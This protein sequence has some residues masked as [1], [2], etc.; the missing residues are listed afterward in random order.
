MARRHGGDRSGRRGGRC[1]A[2]GAGGPVDRRLHT[3]AGD[4]HGG[5]AGHL[6][7]RLARVRPRSRDAFGSIANSPVAGGVASP[8]AR[9][10][11]VD[12]A[13]RAGVARRRPGRRGGGGVVGRWQDATSS[14]V[15]CRRGRQHRTPEH[16][17]L[18]A[19]GSRGGKHFLAVA[20]AA[21]ARRVF[22]DPLRL[23]ASLCFDDAGRGATRRSSGFAHPIAAK[24]VWFPCGSP[25]SVR[26]LTASGARRMDRVGPVV[27]RDAWR[28]SGHD[29]RTRTADLP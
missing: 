19:A 10:P 12:R 26:R 2:H 6:H 27:G 3:P 20:A 4:R 29:A 21:N 11:R 25:A 9:G 13:A 28:R 18:S 15:G 8:R 14:A 23:V 24:T 5:P 1:A 7:H 22:A 17:P 16:S